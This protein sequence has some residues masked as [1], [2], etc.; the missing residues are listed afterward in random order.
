MGEGQSER[1]TGPGR[2]IRALAAGILPRKARRKLMAALRRARRG[3]V[4]FGDL[5]RLTPLSSEF[6]FDRGTPVD[7]YYIEGFLESNADAI[8]G[9]VLEIGTS[10]YTRRFGGDRVVSSEVLHVSED[11]PEVTRIGDL[12]DP[13]LAIADAEFDCVILTQVLQF[14]FETGAALRTAHRVLRPGGDLLLTVAGMAPASRYD[15]ER[16]GEYWRFTS[17]SV[18]RLLRQE[19]PGCEVTTRAHGNVLSGAAFLYGVSA[20]ELAREELDNTDSA[21]EVV[22]TARVHKPG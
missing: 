15:V 19:L 9:R 8:R 14:I 7:R 11:K 4:D 18:E 5:R 2:S 13:D 17:Q 6:G 21:Y 10:M 1:R 3:R 20:E 16:W 22:I 12:T